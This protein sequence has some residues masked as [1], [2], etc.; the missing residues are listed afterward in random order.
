MMR[1]GFEPAHLTVLAPKASSLDH[2]DTASTQKNVREPAGQSYINKRYVGRRRA[3]TCVS[4]PPDKVLHHC[5]LSVVVMTHPPAPALEDSLPC[6]F[7]RPDGPS[8]TPL[9]PRNMA[10]LRHTLSAERPKTHLRSS[11]L[12]SRATEHHPHASSTHHHH[13]HLPPGSSPRHAARPRLHAHR[14]QD[15]ARLCGG[16][17][18]AHLLLVEAQ[19][20]VAQP[21]R[22]ARANNPQARRSPA[23]M[24]G[25]DSRR[26]LAAASTT[27]L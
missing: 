4:T 9:P 13:H 25:S 7:N 2:S 16:G 20:Q 8:Q 21:L 11:R 3:H 17:C 14:E 23:V 18:P 22:P 26:C 24:S 19:C 6:S 15:P 10:T 5:P 27:L 1:T 12:R